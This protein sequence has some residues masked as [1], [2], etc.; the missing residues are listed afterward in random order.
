MKRIKKSI[1]LFLVIC[2]SL[3]MF[4]TTGLYANDRQLYARSKELTGHTTYASENLGK[5]I[6]SNEGYL[7]KDYTLGKGIYISDPLDVDKALYPIWEND[8]IVATF[9]V[10]YVEGEYSGIYSK[11]Y[12][13]QLDELVD[14]TSMD[15]PLNLVVQNDRFYGVIG[16]RWYDLNEEPGSYDTLNYLSNDSELMIIDASQTIYY[17]EI[18]QTRIPTTY[19]KSFTIYQVQTGDYRYSYALGNILMN[20]G[21]SSY[22]PANIQSYM[23]FSL[24]A[25]NSEMVAYL[26]SKGLNASYASNGYLSFSDVQ[27]I[28]YY[29]N[30]YIYIGATNQSTLSSAHAFVIFGYYNDGVSKLYN[31]WNPW[32]SYRQT[33]NATTRIITTEST[34]TYK[35]DLGYIHNIR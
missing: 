22:T 35:W 3:I 7:N 25:S 21:Y 15:Y 17:K 34:R 11:A 2:L 33:M 19:S 13:E 9:L 16:N 24:G 20:M 30:S 18:I 23:N 14:I 32:Y 31:V 27:N 5:Y 10:V 29:N 6:I 1:K 28:I 4:Q 12:A 26:N 8:E